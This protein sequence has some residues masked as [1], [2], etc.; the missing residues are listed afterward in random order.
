MKGGRAGRRG[1]GRG[2]GGQGDGVKGW[3]GVRWVRDRL[4]N[5][6]RHRETQAKKEDRGVATTVQQYIR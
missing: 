2:K 4:M 3:G 5:T 6:P 1:V